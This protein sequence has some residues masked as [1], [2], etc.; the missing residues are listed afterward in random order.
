MGVLAPNGNTVADFWQNSLAGQ[1]GV[2]LI[3]E[4]RFDL[5][6][7]STKFAG[8]LPNDFDPKAAFKTP[9][10]ARKADR[11]TQMAMAATKEAWAQS[12]L[13]EADYEPNRSGVLVGSG[14]GGLK[15]LEDNHVKHL[16]SGPSRISPFMIPMMITNIAS[17]IVSMEYN[18]RGPNYSIVT[19]CA[20]STM[21]I[22]EAFNLIR[23]GE[24]DLFIAGG[25]EAA[26]VPLGV[27]GFAAMKAISTRNDDPT[28]ASRPFDVDRDGF[29][30]GEGAGIMIIEELEHAKQRGANILAEIT[31]YA[32]T[33][34]AY[35]MT[36][37]A[38]EGEG[39]GR[40]MARALEVAGL[41]PDKVDYVNAHG[42][43]TPQGDICESMAI[44]RILGDHADKVWVS[45]IKSM[46]GHLLGAA[47]SVEMA[48][49]I[50]AIETGDVPPTI[51]LD[52]QD[53]ACDL[54]YVPNE[55]R[56]GDINVVMNNSF[57]FG[58]HNACLVAQ[59]YTG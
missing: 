31:G 7:F 18:F 27:G 54:D 14:I 15:S 17:G 28:A 46:I 2:R 16:N 29:V 41:S 20:T 35:H 8:Q 37:P 21:C 44:R 12:G 57:G 33:G 43:S 11:Y 52:N 30:L 1:S 39:A 56:H 42:T 10:D 40:A 6:E 58:G 59:K 48:A 13:T 19:A 25:S 38:P 32:T 47:G 26:V 3:G 50:K 5:S 53:P 23:Y 34:D 22:G 45:S 49:C 51:N 55:A 9:K 24:A 36:S 4:D